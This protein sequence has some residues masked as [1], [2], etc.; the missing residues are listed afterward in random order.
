[1]PE[2]ILFQISKRHALLVAALTLKRCI[3]LLSFYCR[4]AT[5]RKLA[6]KSCN[7]LHLFPSWVI[8]DIPLHHTTEWRERFTLHQQCKCLNRN[9]IYF[10]KFN[11][12][13]QL[14]YLIYNSNMARYQEERHLDF[15]PISTFFILFFSCLLLSMTNLFTT[16]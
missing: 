12:K 5:T 8:E 7:K 6:I 10:S 3:T 2:Y 13:C 4:L 9:Y 14:Q 16:F 11:A 1:M 15:T